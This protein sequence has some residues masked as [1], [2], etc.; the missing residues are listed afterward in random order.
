M[1]KYLVCH[2]R[3]VRRFA[4]FEANTQAEA[5]EK[6]KEN[7]EAISANWDDEDNDPGEFE[8]RDIK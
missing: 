8:V 4:W 5:I 1:P 3:E 6:A 2:A 7:E